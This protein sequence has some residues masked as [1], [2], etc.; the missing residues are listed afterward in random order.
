MFLNP[1]MI[2]KV[3]NNTENQRDGAESKTKNN[4]TWFSKCRLHPIGNWQQ[5]FQCVNTDAATEIYIGITKF[6]HSFFSRRISQFHRTYIS[7]SHRRPRTIYFFHSFSLVKQ[8]TKWYNHQTY[9]N[10]CKET[11]TPLAKMNYSWKNGL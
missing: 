1:I 7:W 2:C 5:K 11:F 8:M 4:L 10:N 3:E 9:G 6:S